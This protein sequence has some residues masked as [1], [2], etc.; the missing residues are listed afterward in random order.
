MPV[1]ASATE[2]G[3]YVRHKA[4]ARVLACMSLMLVCKQ[5]RIQSMWQGNLPGRQVLCANP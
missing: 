2:P 1:N 3:M 4:Y 5:K